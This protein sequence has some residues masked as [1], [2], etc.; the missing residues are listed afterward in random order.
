MKTELI[1]L[2]LSK[3][4]HLSLLAFARHR[5]FVRPGEPSAKSE[6]EVRQA[7]I[8]Q[9]GTHID[10]REAIEVIETAFAAARGSK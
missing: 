4:P 9:L 6:S 2:A 8:A 10:R 3:L 1:H 7:I 5:R